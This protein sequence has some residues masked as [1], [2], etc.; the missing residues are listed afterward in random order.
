MTPVQTISSESNMMKMSIKTHTADVS[1]Q[2]ARQP[3]AESKSK[4]Q[5]RVTGWKKTGD[6][7]DPNPI[8]LSCNTRSTSYTDIRNA[9]VNIV[10][11]RGPATLSWENVTTLAVAAVSVAT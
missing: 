4:K 7:T 6:F 9:Y 5:T 1:I 8:Q 10:L 2:M 11:V 3:A